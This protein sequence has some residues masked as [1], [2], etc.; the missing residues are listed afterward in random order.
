MPVLRACLLFLLLGAAG[1]CAAVPVE[2]VAWVSIT[3]QVAPELGFT[4]IVRTPEGMVLSNE[5]HVLR[6]TAGKR[7][8]SLDQATV[9]LHHPPRDAPTN[10]VR[11]LAWADYERLLQP[12][13]LVTAAAPAR[14]RIVLDAGHGGDDPGAHSGEESVIEKRVTLDIAR[15]AA[16]LLRFAG[17]DVFLTR[18]NDTL[19]TLGERIRF[20]TNRHA[21]V[22][23]SIHANASPTN[24]HAMGT[25]TYVLTAPGFASTE[26][27]PHVALDPCPGNRFDAANARLGFAIHRRCL[28]QMSQDRG[29]RRARYYLL[30]DAPCPA[31]LI[32]CGFLSNTNDAARLGNQ[33]YRRRFAD[34]IAAGIQ[35]Y[36]RVLPSAPPPASSDLDE[37]KSQHPAITDDPPAATGAAPD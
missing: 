23:V 25:E 33:A 15:H 17:H 36:S 34:A 9:W 22:F 28:P 35:D 19:R 29:L 31:V 21:Q 4:N 16:R 26:E 6:L 5:Q 30:R 11:D 18:S 2:T 12:I 3:N 32:E 37:T 24:P 20:A 14:L 1:A 13:L 8:A 27:K 10:D 7:A